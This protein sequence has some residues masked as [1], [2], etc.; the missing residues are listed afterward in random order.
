M[1][2][3][4]PARLGPSATG[5]TDP[6]VDIGERYEYEVF[7]IGDEGRGRSSA[8]VS[9]R[10]PVPPIEQARFGGF[11]GVRLVFRQIDLL[12]RF[13]GVTDPATGART[14]QEW[15]IQPVCTASRG[16]CNVT[17]FGWELVRH[18]R[19]YTGTLP[20]NATCGDQRV[21]SERTVTL[22][23]TKSRVV[24]RVLTVSAFTGVSEVDLPCGGEQVHAVAGIS[25]RLAERG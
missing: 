19:E 10:T 6:G 23:V 11:Y 5:F 15:D 1:L 4:S 8:L 16:A 7:A 2:F 22:Q 20:S 13:E 17:L 24:G 18:G 9:V 21:E 25:G 12:S 3:R 14:F